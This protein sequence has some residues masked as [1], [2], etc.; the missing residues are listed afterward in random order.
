MLTCQALWF[1]TDFSRMPWYWTKI[2]PLPFQ[3]Y[4]VLR[5]Y[6]LFFLF[7]FLGC[8]SGCV[9]ASLQ[10]V[11]SH[12]STLQLVEGRLGRGGVTKLGSGPSGFRPALLLL[13]GDTCVVTRP[14]YGAALWTIWGRLVVAVRVNRPGGL[15]VRHRS[16]PRGGC[17]TLKTDKGIGMCLLKSHMSH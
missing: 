1:Y 9:C 5:R 11:R 7:F 2:T 6:F 12:Q 15:W 17:S 16:A 14:L 10:P 13:S 8:I 3:Y 4:A